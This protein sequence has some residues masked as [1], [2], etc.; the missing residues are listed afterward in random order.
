MDPGSRSCSEAPPPRLVALSTA[1]A[2]AGATKQ[3]ASLRAEKAT[4]TARNAGFQVTRLYR[5]KPDATYEEWT[6]RVKEDFVPI[7]REVS[8]FIEYMLV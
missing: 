7:I 8:S 6:R 3:V 1:I 4:Q 5:L 2:A